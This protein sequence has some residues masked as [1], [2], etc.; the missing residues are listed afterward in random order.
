MLKYSKWPAICKILQYHQNIHNGW[1][2]WLSRGLFS[3]HGYLIDFWPKWI[4]FFF[5]SSA[6]P[7]RLRF[8]FPN[9]F[10]FWSDKGAPCQCTVL[11]NRVG[12][13]ERASLSPIL[14]Q[15]SR[16]VYGAKEKYSGCKCTVWKCHN[17]VCLLQLKNAKYRYR[18]PTVQR[19]VLTHLSK[20]TYFLSLTPMS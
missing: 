11:I 9:V 14:F 1:S 13:P 4:S 20:A 10:Y 12:S 17:I 5:C 19:D 6:H 16:V 8:F 2:H 3:Q 18:A 7:F 15:Q